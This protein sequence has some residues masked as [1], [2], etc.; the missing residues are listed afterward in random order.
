MALPIPIG[1]Q[2]EV[3][4]LPAKGHFVVLGTAG[5]GKTTL[6]ILRAAYLANPKTDHHGKTLLV[7]FNRALVAYLKHLQERRLAYVVVENYHKF[8][9]GYLAFQGK[10][11]S[12]AICR[13]N[14][15]DKLLAQAV[16][17][18]SERYEP[19]P[20]FKWPV[21]RFSEEFRW[22]AQ[23]GITTLEAYEDAERIGRAGVRIDRKLR[24]AVFEIYEAYRDR[25][26]SRGMKYDWD[27]LATAVCVEFDTDDTPR[28]YRH[29]VIDEGQDFSPEMI[30]SLAKAV[31]LDGSLTFFGMSHNRSMGIVC[32]GGLRDSTSQRC[33][34]L[35]RTTEIRSRLL[36]S[37]SLSRRCHISKV[38]LISLHQFRRQQMDLCRLSLNVFRLVRKS[39]LSL[40][41]PAEQQGR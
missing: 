7:T 1:R 41:K 17:Q 12:H 34:N 22:M 23:H 33:G 5:S 18:I 8:A 37:V 36:A 29:V 21:A 20:L 14:Q 4:C 31:P 27:D 24:G 32:R 11:P 9:R 19:H 15:R 13:S 35:K 28:R 26:E 16:K 10:M 6:A 39:N 38:S 25:R 3:L 30:R 2:K 40:N